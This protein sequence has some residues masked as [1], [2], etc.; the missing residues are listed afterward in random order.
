MRDTHCT[1][2]LNEDWGMHWGFLHLVTG[3]HTA[4]VSTTFGGRGGGGRQEDKTPG[5]SSSC[6]AEPIQFKE[7]GDGGAQEVTPPS[8]SS[9]CVITYFVKPSLRVSMSLILKK[10]YI[11][12]CGS[13]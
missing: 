9:L 11:F 6:L 4:R 3:W 5:L 2:S 10:L 13:W 7:L 12:N 8:E 1:Q